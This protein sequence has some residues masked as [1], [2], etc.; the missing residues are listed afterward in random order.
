MNDFHCRQL[1]LG[2]SYKN[3]Y[4]RVLDEYATNEVALQRITLL[5][6]VPFEKELTALH[7]TTKKFINIFR[8][9]KLIPPGQNGVVKNY[10]ILSGIPSRFPAPPQK[11]LVDGPVQVSMAYDSYIC[12]SPAR[13][14]LFKFYHS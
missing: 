4:V 6:G 1:C 2:C 9:S 7:F 13:L 11:H 3:D 8:D 10:N 14:R 12:I 5:E